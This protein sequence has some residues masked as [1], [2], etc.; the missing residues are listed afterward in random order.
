M[1]HAATMPSSI[2]WGQT[3]SSRRGLPFVVDLGDVI[4]RQSNLEAADMLGD[5]EVDVEQRAGRILRRR[6][7]QIIVPIELRAD[8]GALK[9]DRRRRIGEG[10]A[11]REIVNIVTD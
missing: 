8:L 6:V 4:A 1:A 9:Q 5:G 10:D 7:L 3:W 2:I 11:R